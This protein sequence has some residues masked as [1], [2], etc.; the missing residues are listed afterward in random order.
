MGDKKILTF[1]CLVNLVYSNDEHQLKFML[2]SIMKDIMPVGKVNVICDN[3]L[4][5]HAMSKEFMVTRSFLVLRITLYFVPMRLSHPR[6]SLTCSMQGKILD[7][8]QLGSSL[9]LLKT[10][11]T[12]YKTLTLT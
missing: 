11:T 9:V 5:R 1:L 2:D 6:C 7:L 8:A 10:L 3:Q 4:V 12:H